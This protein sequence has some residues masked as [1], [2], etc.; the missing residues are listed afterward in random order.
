MQQR[1]MMMHFV[2]ACRDNDEEKVRDLI[3]KGVD[4]NCICK[5]ES[6]WTPLTI[7]TFRFCGKEFLLKFQG[8]ILAL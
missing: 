4:V 3:A 6:D 7:A 5:D 8:K 1:R 2:W